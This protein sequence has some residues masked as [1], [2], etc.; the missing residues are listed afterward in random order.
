MMKIG[1]LKIFSS[2]YLLKELW[3][4]MLSKECTSKPASI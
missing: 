2:L 1:P 4:M 3:R